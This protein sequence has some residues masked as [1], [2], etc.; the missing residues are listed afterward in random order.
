MSSKVNDVFFSSQNLDFTFNQVRQKVINKTG[1]DILNKPV[2]RDSYN[3]LATIVYDKTPE[4]DHNLVSLNNRLED[5][6][7][8]HFHKIIE[9]KR[10]G[11]PKGDRPAQFMPPIN[12]PSIEEP[13]SISGVN[14]ITQHHASINRENIKDS[15]TQVGGTSFGMESSGFP[16]DPLMDTRVIPSDHTSTMIDPLDFDFGGSS[17]YIILKNLNKLKICL[18]WIE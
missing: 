1:Y 7:S 4:T 15:R 9:K 10:L 11:H 8:S 13:T 12:K 18:L 17:L 3:K 2:F 6:C 14:T 16:I 5:K